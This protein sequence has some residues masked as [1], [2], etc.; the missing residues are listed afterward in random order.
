M[1]K[2]YEGLRIQSKT[3]MAMMVMKNATMP[4]TRLFMKT[5]DT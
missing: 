4:K 1:H 3:K 5:Q 2:D